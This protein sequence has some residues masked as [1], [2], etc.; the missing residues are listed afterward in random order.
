MPGGTPVKVSPLDNDEELQRRP[1]RLR[2]NVVNSKQQQQSTPEQNSEL[3]AQKNSEKFFNRQLKQK[4]KELPGLRKDAKGNV[5]KKR[6]SIEPSLKFS[7]PETPPPSFDEYW[8]EVA[9]QWIPHKAPLSGPP[10]P[11]LFN[12]DRDFPPLNRSVQRSHLPP[13]T[14]KTPL[15]PI[16]PST[17]RETS[18]SSPAEASVSPLRKK[19]PSIDPFPSLPNINDFSRPITD[20]VDEKNNTIMITSNNTPLPPIGQ[21]QLS[22]ELNKIFSDVDNTIKEKANTFKEQTLDI[23]EL[24]EK[25]GK[26]E[27]SEATF[28]FEFFSG[29]KN[30]KFD[31]FIKKFDLTTQNINFIDFLQSEYYKEILQN[32]DLKIHI[33]TG[34]IYYD[35]KDTNESI[36]EFIQNQQNTS[37]GIIPYDFKFDRNFRDYFK[38]ILNEFDA[39]QKTTF[40]V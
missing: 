17:P 31:S 36:F 24:V 23:D 34:N 16:L 10:E 39:Q 19:L 22:Q 3:I 21:K 28:E 9:D 6:S 15:L 35:D 8:D 32:N 40:D 18:F 14:P 12:Y 2:G 11:P 1:D 4:E 26:D 33:K 29:G 25:V 13:I 30:S 38:W 27:K 37:K 7:L 20:V 5:G